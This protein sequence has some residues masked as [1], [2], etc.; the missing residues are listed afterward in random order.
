MAPHRE[1]QGARFVDKRLELSF[2]HVKFKMV[3]L[4]IQLLVYHGEII[5]LTFQS[6]IFGAILK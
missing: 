2:R 3:F 5:L 4:E 6:L 1:G